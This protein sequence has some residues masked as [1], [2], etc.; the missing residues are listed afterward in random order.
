MAKFRKIKIDPN[1]EPA[2]IWA[3]IHDNMLVSQSVEVVAVVGPNGSI[4]KE[5]RAWDGVRKDTSNS[6]KASPNTNY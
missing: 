1:A 4:V 5:L 2:D 3:E 6:D